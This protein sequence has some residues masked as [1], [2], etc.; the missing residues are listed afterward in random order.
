MPISP[1]SSDAAAVVI[2]ISPMPPPPGFLL[3]PV[4][5]TLRCLRIFFFFRWF[6]VFAYFQYSDTPAIY[7]TGCQLLMRCRHDTD[8]L[9][10]I[11]M[12]P[13]AADAEYF[14]LAFT[15]PHYA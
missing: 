15:P 9:R 6:S 12:M 11:F 8:T 7:F 2:V 14:E 10:F 13:P 1:L 3:L 5:A 4:Y